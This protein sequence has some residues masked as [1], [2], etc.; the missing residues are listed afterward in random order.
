MSKEVR[1]ALGNY[2][3][4]LAL[5][6]YISSGYELLEQQYRCKLGEIDLIFQKENCL[7]FVEVRTKTNDSFGLA[8]ESITQ[9]KQETIRKVA[10]FYLQS[11]RFQDVNLQFDVV[12]IRISKKEKK[13]WMK[14]FAQAF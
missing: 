4:G 8:E 2:G 12:A 9:R 7:Y 5:R 14:R 11:N 1:K 3:E 13:A 6:E 10:Q